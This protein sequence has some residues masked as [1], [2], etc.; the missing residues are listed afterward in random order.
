[1]KKSLIALAVLGLSGAAFAQSSVTLYG[2]ADIG[3]GKAPGV[4]VHRDARGNIIRTTKQ[5]FQMHSNMNGSSRVGLRGV[6]DLGGGLKVGFQ[7]ETGLNLETGAAADTFWARQANLWIGGNWGTLKLGR[8]LTVSN[9][10]QNLWDPTGQAGYS[11]SGNTYGYA[12]AGSRAD[13]AI[14]YVTPNFSGFQAGLAFVSKTETAVTTDKHMYD[15]GLWY[16][17]GPLAAGF[18]YN[19]L[20]DAKGQYQIGGKYNFNN[21]F[22]SAAYQATGRANNGA[23]KRNGVTLGAGAKFGAFGLALDV[24]RDTKRP[25]GVKKYTNVALEGKYDLSKRT[26]FYGFYGRQ[27]GENGYGLGIR[28]NF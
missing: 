6:E 5:V 22:L 15:L 25:A 8:Q 19:K 9:Q 16:N 23:D 1:M 7:F 18:S 24:T 17:N 12:G 4:V 13:S 20:G 3:Y 14:S 26:F 21:F 2:V 11:V 28:H 10:V 27:D